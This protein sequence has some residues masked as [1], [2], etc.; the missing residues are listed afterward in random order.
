V[1][2]K[3]VKT[4]MYYKCV[5]QRGSSDLTHLNTTHMLLEC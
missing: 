3:Y 5:V 1:V 2:A 4:W